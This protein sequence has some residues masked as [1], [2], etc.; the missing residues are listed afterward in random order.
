MENGSA[1]GEGVRGSFYLCK[2]RDGEWAVVQGLNDWEAQ[3]AQKLETLGDHPRDWGHYV[4]TLGQRIS[5]LGKALARLGDAASLDGGG[6]EE[7]WWAMEALADEIL[8]KAQKAVAII[9][10]APPPCE[11][12][13]LETN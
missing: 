13:G 4:L 5:L 12:K 6:G 3:D 1:K 10:E 11:E 7:D 9:R 8:E 2:T